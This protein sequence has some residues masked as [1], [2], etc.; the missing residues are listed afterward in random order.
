FRSRWPL[1]TL[2]RNDDPVRLRQYRDL[3]HFTSTQNRSVVSGHWPGSS[4]F[5]RSQL[6][7]PMPAFAIVSASTNTS[8]SPA[9]ASVTVTVPPVSAAGYASE[10]DSARPVKSIDPASSVHVP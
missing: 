2:G 3:A 10:I 9:A 7:R 8:N 6:V 5:S 1:H 4:I